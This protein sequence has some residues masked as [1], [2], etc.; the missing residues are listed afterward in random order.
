MYLDLLK[1]LE[2]TK[3]KTL[4]FVKNKAL[5]FKAKPTLNSLELNKVFH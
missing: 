3:K 1:T 2:A 5:P 4:N